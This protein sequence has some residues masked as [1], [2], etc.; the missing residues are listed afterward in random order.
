M[1]LLP[2]RVLGGRPL[3][4]GLGRGLAA[5]PTGRCYHVRRP[6]VARVQQQAQSAVSGDSSRNAAVLSG[7]A[8][9]TA[10]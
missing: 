1:L 8:V 3:G 2:S 5:L 10:A 6:V 9:S 4:L 7:K